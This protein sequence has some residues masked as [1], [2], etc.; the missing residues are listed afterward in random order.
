MP[1]VPPSLVASNCGRKIAWV[2]I[3]RT[4]DI[5]SL[6]G[7]SGAGWVPTPNQTGHRCA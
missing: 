1:T 4:V 6:Q 2:D 3:G 7:R 5:E